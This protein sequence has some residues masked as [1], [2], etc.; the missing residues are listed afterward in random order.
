MYALMVFD[1]MMTLMHHEQAGE[2]NPMF[3]K[4]L[5][6][7]PIA[8]IYLKLAFNTSAALG[9]LILLKQRPLMGKV[10]A[11]LGLLIYAFVAYLHVEVYRLNHDQNPLIPAF[12]SILDGFIY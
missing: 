5:V 12:I 7:Q 4:I 2:L 11:F 9:I 10:F 6:G 8:F 1:L 3:A